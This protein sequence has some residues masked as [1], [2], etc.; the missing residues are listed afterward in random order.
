MKAILEFDLNDPD[1]AAAHKR[2]VLALDM[3]MCLHDVKEQFRSKIKY[4][5]NLTEDEVKGWEDAREMFLGTL[6]EYNIDL[7]NL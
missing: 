3:M 5:D 2:A 7:N 6:S 1:D 4:D